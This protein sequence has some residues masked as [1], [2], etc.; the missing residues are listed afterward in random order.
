MA[1]EIK[2]IVNLA[3]DQSWSWLAGRAVGRYVWNLEFDV[4]RTGMAE[5][6]ALPEV[7]LRTRLRGFYRR[8]G[9]RRP[10]ERLALRGDTR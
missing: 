2:N 9:L 10:E 5:L 4:E 7:R 3:A 6:V 8:D 1:V